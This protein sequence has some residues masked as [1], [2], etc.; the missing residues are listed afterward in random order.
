MRLEFGEEVRELRREVH[1][2]LRWTVG[3]DYSDVDY[4]AYTF[5]V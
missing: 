1:S 2:Y 3:V 4:Y 5:A